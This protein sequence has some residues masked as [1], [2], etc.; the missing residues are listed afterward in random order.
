M[1]PYAFE[2]KIT[3]PAAFSA[4]HNRPYSLWL[5]SADT[6]HP[7]GRYSYIAF[8]P[9]ETIEAK[10]GRVTIT[11]EWQKT[12][13]KADPFKMAQERLAAWNAD[14]GETIPGLP[15]FQGGIAGLFGYDLARGLETLPEKSLRNPMIPDMALGL[16]DRLIAFDHIKKK[17]WIVVQASDKEDAE[18]KRAE[19][20][21]E[22]K[23][24]PSASLPP[25]AKSGE[26]K[27]TWKPL[28]KKDEYK[29]D[30]QKIIDY[31]RAGDLF[32]ANLSQRFEAVLPPGYNPF[33]HYLTLRTVNPAPFAAYMNIGGVIIAS[34]SPEQ[35]LS[36]EDGIVTTRPIK[37]TIP[38]GQNK[39]DDAANRKKLE[40]S[41]KDR[42]EN[43]MIVDL[44]R[45][46]LSKVCEPNSIELVD[47]CKTESFASVHHLVSTIRGKLKKTPMEL[48]RACFP[49]GS[50]TGAPK[51]RAMEIIEELE[52]LRRGPYC[53]SIGWVGFDGT[54]DSNILIRTLVYQG[55]RVSL[56]TGGGIT[57]Q[58][59]PEEEYEETLIKAARILKSFEGAQ[60]K[61][62]KQA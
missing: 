25:P 62:K 54:M 7:A 51:I 2:T 16:Y 46:D 61:T 23:P 28:Y 21:S 14:H 52:P 18:Q 31:I 37:G 50:I 49:G 26:K 32:Q 58:S 55:N 57:A 9:V 43:I 4:L 47:L 10:D 42:A 20:F 44:L 24:K 27:L 6:L 8:S 48:L 3:A 38:R 17:A 60:E 35:F 29:A 12:T 11:N 15:P 36:V 1:K 33:A 45:N 39:E 41:F 53:G 13:I 56:Q 22:L 40:S 59:N 19:V 30:I 34:A 5:D